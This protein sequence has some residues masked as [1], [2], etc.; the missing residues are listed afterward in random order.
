MAVVTT[1]TQIL[2]LLARGVVDVLDWNG[3]RSHVRRDSWRTFAVR[4]RRTRV[5]NMLR[6]H[7]NRCGC[8]LELDALIVVVVHVTHLA[9]VRVRGRAA[10]IALLEMRRRSQVGEVG[11]VPVQSCRISGHAGRASV[12]HGKG[13]VVVHVLARRVGGGAVRV[14]EV[15]VVAGTEE[16]RVSAVSR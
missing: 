3:M 1:P 6:G 10:E 5:E 16:R 8:V 12:V 11:A 15:V 4:R 7:G 13:S 9:I 2:S 14:V